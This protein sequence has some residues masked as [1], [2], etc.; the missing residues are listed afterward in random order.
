MKRRSIRFAVLRT[1]DAPEAPGALETQ[2]I[3]AD[4]VALNWSKPVSDGGG[5]IKGYYVEKRDVSGP[6]V[7]PVSATAKE[8]QR[9]NL[10]PLPAC[11]FNVPNLIEEHEYE[12]RVF[13]ENEAGLS[14]PSNASRRVRV[15]D[16][17]AATL[18]EFVVPLKTMQVCDAHNIIYEH[19]HTFMSSFR[20]TL[21]LY[22]QF[23]I[24]NIFTNTYCEIQ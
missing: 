23:S 3:G 10:V 22:T 17:R 11:A 16:P 8:W 21:Y 6:Q 24:T 15:K 2:E 1:A 18:A 20:C 5:R 13:A 12:F 19:E 9:C 7:G 4:F 14:K